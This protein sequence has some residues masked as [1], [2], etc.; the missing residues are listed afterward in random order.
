MKKITKFIFLFI[1]MFIFLTG[2]ANNEDKDKANLNEYNLA[3]KNIGKFTED[4][5]RYKENISS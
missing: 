4:L 2:C 5:E 1:A 3:T